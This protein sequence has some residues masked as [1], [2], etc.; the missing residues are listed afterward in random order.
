[1]KKWL[2]IFALL[3]LLPALSVPAKAAPEETDSPVKALRRQVSQSYYTACATAGKESFHGYCGM[4]VAHQLNAVG[5]TRGALQMDG[6]D[7]FNYYAA[8]KVTNAGYHI[9]PYGVQEFSLQ[10]ALE[11]ITKDGTRDAYNILVGFQWTNTDAGRQFGHV[12][13]IN[14]ILDG[15]VYFAESFYCPLGGPEGTVITCTIEEFARYFNRWA[16]FEGLIHFGSYQDVCRQEST[17][18]FLRARFDSALRSQPCLVGDNGCVQLRTVAAGERLHATGIYEGDRGLYYK[19]A[20]VDGHAFISAAAASLL[21]LGGETLNLVAPEL[22]TQLQPGQTAPISG[23]VESGYGTVAAVEVLI[24]DASGEPVRRERADTADGVGK[25]ETLSQELYLDL[26]EEGRYTLEVYADCA[27]PVVQG[28]T[29]VTQYKRSRVLSQPL[30]VGQADVAEV[31]APFSRQQTMRNGWIRTGGT[32]YLYDMDAPVT[33]WVTDCG[34][35]YYL[36][37]TGAISTGWQQVDGQL[38]YFSSEGAL[39]TGCQIARED[40]LYMLD[41]NGIATEFIE[42]Q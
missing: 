35:R 12:V 28:S 24:S 21:S 18:I 14:G 22:P 17:D 23:T 37:Q 42:S 11:E 32:W 26:L 27:C 4:M 13:F 39:V 3:C 10:Q 40:K 7:Q 2:C 34:V 29:V 20:T 1:M 8:R 41:E 5:I 15:I 16:S 31:I 25:L 38:M 19:V 30:Q 9:Q 33:G 6:R 36:S